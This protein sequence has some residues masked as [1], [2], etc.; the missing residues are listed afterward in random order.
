MLLG[1]QKLTPNT[2]RL[3]RGGLRRGFRGVQSGFGVQR[4]MLWGLAGYRGTVG[5]RGARQDLV[6]FTKVQWGTEEAQQGAMGCS[7]VQ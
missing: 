7:G 3:E 5:C 4:G 6:G 2:H 1:W